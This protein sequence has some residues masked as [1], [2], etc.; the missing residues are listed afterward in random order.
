[1]SD[2]VDLFVQDKDGFRPATKKE[3]EKHNKSLNE[4]TP[5]KPSDDKQDGV[6][7]DQAK[8]EEST[9]EL[10][11][12]KKELA[13]KEKELEETKKQLSE[14]EQCFAKAKEAY[15]KKK[16]ENKQLAEQSKT[17]DEQFKEL[18]DKLQ[19]LEEEFKKPVVKSRAYSESL[20]AAKEL[21]DE[22]QDRILLETMGREIG[23][24]GFGDNHGE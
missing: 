5:P 17:K 13:A 3:L 6:S 18:S 24:N 11:D 4:D 22:E 12:K 16:E 9:K 2:K 21:S 7:E 20:K 8:L 23:R 14:K 1:M 19:S 10:D 15:K